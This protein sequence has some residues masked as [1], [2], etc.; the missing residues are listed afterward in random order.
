M[1]LTRI[2]TL[3]TV[4]TLGMVDCGGNDNP[5]GPTN[6]SS[7]TVM[8]KDSPFDDARSILVTFS[9]VSAHQSGDA[10]MSVPFADGASTRTCDLKKLTGGTTDV[11]AV[12][13]VPLGHYT[14][15][16]LT[17]S[18]AALYFDNESSGPACASSIAAPLGRSAPLTIPSGVVRLNRQFEVSSDTRHSMLLDFDGDRSIRET[19][20]G[21]FMMTPVITIVSFE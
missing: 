6:G 5:A 2:V 18:S 16:R 11:L 8:L 19:G 10:F 9:E 7:F 13:A 21:K 20:S 14:M 12:G 15:I 4:A 1:P 3:L 17:V